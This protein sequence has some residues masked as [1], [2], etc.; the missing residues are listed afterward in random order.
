MLVKLLVVALVLAILWM[1][2][3]PRTVP[4]ISRRV[5]RRIGDV[6]RAGHEILTDEEV[7]GSPLGRYETQIGRA[8]TARVLMDRTLSGNLR[9]QE[10]VVRIGERLASV[11]SRREI[12]YRFAV[13]EDAEPQA[14]A[15]PGG[16]VFITTGL[17]EV[18]GGDDS[19]VA[20]ILGHE[21]AHIDLRHALK[22]EAARVATRT[23]LRLLTMRGGG[24]AGQLAA[25]LQ[26][27]I[28]QG[29]SQDR[30]LE[31]DRHGT[32]LASRAD[33]DPLALARLFLELEDQTEARIPGPVAALATYFRSHPP[34]T[35]RA[36]ALQKQWRAAA[37]RTL[38]PIE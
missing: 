35:D 22:S 18:C 29:Y 16:S 5:G 7:P 10:R 26:P 19:R 28:I 20:G 25:Q 30:E 8:L 11:A 36:H 4:G 15:V 31:A 2:L 1:V 34:L 14:F 17:V 13:V 38:P 37:G 6:K 12:R 32:S 23:G 24:L 9:L 33:Y 21:I 27:L 3:F